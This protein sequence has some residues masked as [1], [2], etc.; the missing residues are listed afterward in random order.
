MGDENRGNELPQR[1]DGA[2]PAGPYPPGGEVTTPSVKTGITLDRPGR[3]AGSDRAAQP[4]RVPNAGPVAEDE[5]TEWFGA[6]APGPAGTG[7][8]AGDDPGLTAP[9]SWWPGTMVTA[10]AVLAGL[11]IGAL[12]A[13]GVRHYSRPSADAVAASRQAAIRDQA[14]SWVTRQVSRQVRVSC[15]PAV[16]AAL[17]ARGFPARDL[18]T[19]GPASRSAATTAVV[20]ETS[21]VRQLFG[22]SL[23]AAWAPDVLASFG[24]GADGI[25]VR[26]IAPHGAAAYQVLLGTGLAAREKAGAALLRDRRVT[27]PAAAAGQLDSG[28]VDS[29][30]LRALAALARRQPIS[31]AGFGTTGPGASAGLPLRFADLAEN[32]PAAHLTRTAYLRSVCAHLDTMRARFGLTAVTTVLPPYGPRVLRVEVTAP[33]PPGRPDGNR[34]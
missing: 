12:T 16:C 5:V 28:L 29:R 15:D 13:A 2:P 26:V 23:D 14:A 32:D 10:G 17:R 19:L 20:V 21:V 4:V 27:I 6:A 33:G 18:L 8:A 25:T 24:S 7:P 22:T 30:L 11:V 34:G 1:A 31:I 9:G 3:G